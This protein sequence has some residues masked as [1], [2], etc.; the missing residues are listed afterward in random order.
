[1]MQAAQEVFRVLKAGGFLRFIHQVWN[2]PTPYVETIS[3][4]EGATDSQTLVP[5]LV[6]TIRQQNPNREIRTVLVLDSSNNTSELHQKLLTKS[7]QLP[8][9]YGEALL[10]ELSSEAIFTEKVVND[11]EKL[12]RDLF[13]YETKRYTTKDLVDLLTRIGFTNI[14]NT[15]IPVVA[16]DDYPEIRKGSKDLFQVASRKLGTLDVLG[17]GIITANKSNSAD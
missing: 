1:M 16:A 10:D 2:L 9:Q 7:A 5:L 15:K 14:K 13:T 3:L 17:E 11:L 8:S 6:H 4:I 12:K